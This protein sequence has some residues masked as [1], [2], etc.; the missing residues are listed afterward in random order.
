MI[1]VSAMAPLNTHSKAT[2]DQ[3]KDNQTKP[4][5]AASYLSAHNV[6]YVKLDIHIS[7]RISRYRL[8]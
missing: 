2:N 7:N 1:K 6:Y 4:D 3:N 5:S 8:P